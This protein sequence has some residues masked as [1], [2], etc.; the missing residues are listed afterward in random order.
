MMIFTVRDLMNSE[1][2]CVNPS[3]GIDHVV[4]TLLTHGAS[5]VYVVDHHDRLMGVV[6]DYE[7]LKMQLTETHQ[8]LTAA[9]IMNC[10][11]ETTDTNQPITELA[12]RL[13]SSYVSRLAVLHQG[14]L[15][16]VLTRHS[17][18]RLLAAL[19]NTHHPDIDENEEVPAVET[20]A[21]AEVNDS[22]GTSSV[23]RQPVEV[24]TSSESNTPEP[25]IRRPVFLRRQ[26]HAMR[27]VAPPAAFDMLGLYAEPDSDDVQETRDKATTNEHPEPV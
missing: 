9:C 13:R 22:N 4:K 11:V 5:E 19:E 12:M 17:L 8:N 6:S 25:T 18:I 7:V 16:G 14:R 24:E 21:V 23:D 10:H 15:I 26:T 3:D 20:P 1:M 27:R 2:P